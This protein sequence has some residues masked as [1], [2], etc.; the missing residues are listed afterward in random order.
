[1][2]QNLIVRSPFANIFDMDLLNDISNEGLPAL[3]SA[4]S[5]KVDVVENEREFLVNA[6]LPGV[7]KENIHVDFNNGFLTVTAEG[8]TVKEEK[9]GEKIW[10]MERS[11]V[12]K[13][14]S[15]KFDIPIDE[16]SIVAKYENG[17]LALN[18]PKKVLSE[19]T[20]KIQVE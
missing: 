13:S 10:R 12:K 9:E 7:A 18:L 11:F 6:D 17:V 4:M 15:F 8:K 14:R 5:M 16:S 2:L 3:K 20:S 19:K 1:M